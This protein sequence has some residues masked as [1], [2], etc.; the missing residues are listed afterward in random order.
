MRSMRISIAAMAFLA[1][2]V[3]A[4]QSPN[5]QL[6]TPDSPSLE[7]PRLA[8]RSA[9]GSSSNTPLYRELDLLRRGGFFEAP[10]ARASLKIIGK[11]GVPPNHVEV[12][13][14]TLIVNGTP[15]IGRLQAP[16]KSPDVVSPLVLL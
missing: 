1:A 5:A 14:Y 8:A 3:C 2:D 13:E 6:P 15:R 11:D 4:P 16:K 12:A 10:E 9:A 7:N